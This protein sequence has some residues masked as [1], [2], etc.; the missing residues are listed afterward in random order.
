MGVVVAG[1]D[2]F[3]EYHE[4]GAGLARGAPQI[5]NAEVEI[6]GNIVGNHGEL[7]AGHDNALERGGTGGF[8]GCSAFWTH[9][10]LQLSREH[11][12]GVGERQWRFDRQRGVAAFAEREREKHEK[13]R[14]KGRNGRKW[15][16]MR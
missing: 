12:A 5:M 10:N 11:S 6:G 1:G 2:G 9:N 16:K 14:K 3:G 8:T 7:G 15:A 4:L 13:S